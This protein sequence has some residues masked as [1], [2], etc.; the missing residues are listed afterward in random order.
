MKKSPYLCTIKTNKQT[1][2]F[3]NSKQTN[4]MNL[5]QARALYKERIAANN[6]LDYYDQRSTTAIAKEVFAEFQSNA[7]ADLFLTEINRIYICNSGTTEKR[8]EPLPEFWELIG[9]TK[10][11]VVLGSH[12]QR[13]DDGWNTTDV[14]ATVEFQV[15]RLTADNIFSDENCSEKLSGEHLYAPSIP[16]D[17]SRI[18]V[19]ETPIFGY[20]MVEYFKYSSPAILAL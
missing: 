2:S 18:S 7:D 10:K 14:T 8:G 19:S 9:S 12:S 11:T 1:I 6:A 17:G 5:E 15:Y 3:N 13:D 4:K 16:H 20:R